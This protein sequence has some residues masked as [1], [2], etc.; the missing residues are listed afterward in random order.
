M[1]TESVKTETPP[2]SACAAQ[3]ECYEG[4]STEERAVRIPGQIFEFKKNE[5]GFVFSQENLRTIRRYEAAVRLLPPREAVERNTAYPVLGLDVEDI[6]RFFENL[7][8]HA[9]SWKAIED[10]CKKMGND[11][12]VFSESFLFEG[13][14]LLQAISAIASWDDEV[15]T[16]DTVNPLLSNE[17]KQ[18]FREKVDQYLP[19]ILEDINQCLEG[20]K[21]VKALVNRYGE[22]IND[23]LKPM[24][25]G[26]LSRIKSDQVAERLAALEANLQELDEG[27]KK[28]LDEYNGLVGQAF[29][30][31]RFGLIGLIVTGGI[32]GSQAETVRKEKNRMITRRD[33][34]SK[35]K[36][37]LLG[38][39]VGFEDVRTHIVDIEFRLVDVY[40]AVKNL[41]DVWGLLVAYTTTS[42]R[43]AL[44]VST[45][46]ELKDFSRSFERVLRPWEK[47]QNISM[48]LSKLFN[49]ALQ[50]TAEQL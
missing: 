42:Q 16:S 19:T 17:D 40:T 34:L 23:N 8:T 15:A 45:R 10:A 6:V 48:H 12:Q 36:I 5:P 7:L 28:K 29:Q 18:T 31:L 39:T 30:G 20:I 3:D 41:E 4:L 9:N 50:P 26:L 11:L 13:N 2:E 14:A 35:E 25:S 27:I 33:K 37:A 49:E 32:Y 22:D 24:A 1:G 43:R 46:Q 44:S 38:G 47:I 21:S